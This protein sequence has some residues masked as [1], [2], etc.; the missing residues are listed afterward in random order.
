MLLLASRFRFVRAGLNLIIMLLLDT[1]TLRPYVFVFLILYVIGSSVHLGLKR[2]LL[3]GVAGY[4]VA[5]LSEFSSIHTGF[6]YGSYYYI[7]ETRGREIWVLGVPLM[8]SLS[9]VFLVYASYSLSLMI[10]AP[11]RIVKRFVYVL[12]TK[13]HRS[14]LFTAFL[15]A[16]LFVYLD[17]IID[18]V[19]LKGDRWFL[20]LIY[21]YPRG[22]L[23]F[24]VPLSNFAGWFLTGFIMIF[25]LQRIDRLLDRGKA[26]EDAGQRYPWRYLIGPSLYLG[27]LVFNLSVTFFIGE[28]M[29]GWV[30]LFLVLLPAVLVYSIIR[31]K[32]Y[33]KTNEDAGEEH[34]RDFPMSA[35]A[36][37]SYQPNRFPESKEYPAAKPQR[38]QGKHFRKAGT[39]DATKALRHEEK[40]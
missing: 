22:G 30:G 27:V 32:L 29:M 23:Y 21:G 28:Y 16:V 36:P 18:P 26:G 11:V 8:D 34:I 10:T 40:L 3:F 20:G 6:P 17:I 15:G 4:A 38:A 37:E 35:I 14:S 9:Y 13:A 12:E 31:I 39:K 5:W 33:G 19:A 25:T 7:E 2:T 24:G 1:I